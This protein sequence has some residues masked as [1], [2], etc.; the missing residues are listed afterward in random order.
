M[1]LVLFGSI[2]PKSFDEYIYITSVVQP[3]VLNTQTEVVILEESII[4]KV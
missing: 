1:L 4:K 3:V 2:P